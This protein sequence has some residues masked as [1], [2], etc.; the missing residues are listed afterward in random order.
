MR[1]FVYGS[2]KQG[3]SNDRLCRNVQ[4]EPATMWGQLYQQAC[5]YPMLVI[6]AD[7]VLAVG[8]GVPHADAALEQGWDVSATRPAF[9]A[10][11]GW[12]LIQGELVTFG[13]VEARLPLLDALEDFHPPRPCVYQRVLTWTHAPAALTWTYVAPHGVLPPGCTALADRWPG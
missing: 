2:L 5:G 3:E 4:V 10:G 8:S 7:A 1:L 9:V 11:A 6:P 13:D 12:R